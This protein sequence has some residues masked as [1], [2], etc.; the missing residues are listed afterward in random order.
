MMIITSF[1]SILSDYATPNDR[2]NQKERRSE[3][4]GD[5]TATDLHLYRYDTPIH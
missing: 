4:E 3:D 1:G 2:Q 5:A